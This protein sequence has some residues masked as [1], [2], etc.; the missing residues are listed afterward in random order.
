MTSAATIEASVDDA[1]APPRRIVPAP[2]N[3][4]VQF[5]PASPF[6][7]YKLPSGRSLPIPDHLARFSLPSATP[8]VA[9]AMHG[10]RAKYEDNRWIGADYKQVRDLIREIGHTWTPPDLSIDFIDD[11]PTRYCLKRKSLAEERFAFAYSAEMFDGH[12]PRGHDD[13]WRRHRIWSSAPPLT[14]EQ[15]GNAFGSMLHVA[16]RLTRLG[17]DCDIAEP[18]GRAW[19]AAIKILPAYHDGHL[20]IGAAE[21]LAATI[22][23]ETVTWSLRTKKSPTIPNAERW[24]LRTMGWAS[25]ALM[26]AGDSSREAASA[27]GIKQSAALE[28]FGRDVILIERLF[29]RYCCDYNSLDI[30]TQNANPKWY[31]I[32]RIWW[33]V[34]SRWRSITP[35]LTKPKQI[36]RSRKL[37]WLTP[38]VIEILPGMK[39]WRAPQIIELLKPGLAE[40]YPTSAYSALPFQ[41]WLTTSQSRQPF[42]YGARCEP[43]DIA[44]GFVEPDTKPHYPVHGLTSAEFIG[45]ANQGTT[46]VVHTHPQRAWHFGLTP[47]RL[48]KQRKGGAGDVDC[49]IDNTEPSRLGNAGNH[50]SEQE[51]YLGGNRNRSDGPSRREV[52]WRDRERDLSER[53]QKALSPENEGRFAP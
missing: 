35:R 6:R 42:R 40:D 19:W 2:W 28:R 46:L 49:E 9:A 31:N 20:K 47:W 53:F 22:V 8:R 50:K 37:P 26:V 14:P 27:V 32:R 17:L 51:F 10:P 7:C 33:D 29:G 18:A 15:L 3:S 43:D 21:I 16:D 30:P 1:A 38:W 12:T 4:A 23:N 25:T 34:E 5:Q 52:K 11:D 24:R 41:S 44:L 48:E 36:I 45:L 13:D 39:P